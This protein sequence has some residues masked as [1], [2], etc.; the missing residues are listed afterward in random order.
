MPSPRTHRPLLVGMLVAGTVGGAALLVIAATSGM[1][2]FDSPLAV[3]PPSDTPAGMVWV[4][5][6]T[7]RMGGEDPHPGKRA[8]ELPVHDV[9]LDGFWM[10]A[11]E[12]TNAQ[13]AA[14]VAATGYATAAERT[15]RREDFAGQTDIAAI[16]DEMLVPGSICFN[17]NFDRETLRQGFPGWEYQVWRQ[18]EGANWREPEGPGSSIANRMDHPVVHVAWDDAVAYCRWAGKDL[19]TEAEWE[20]A[21]RGG[22]VGATYPWGNELRPDGQWRNNIWQGKFPFENQARDGFAATAPVQ[23]F[24]PND[25]GLFDMSGNVWEW[26]ADWYRPDYYENSKRRNPAG[27]DKSFDPDEPR[28]PKRVQRGGS[29]M[30][31]DDYCIGYRAA[32]RMKG[33]PSSGAFHTGFRCVVRAA[34]LDEYRNAPAHQARAQ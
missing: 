18:V 25:Y 17:P 31:S 9:A 1:A 21:A 7:F 32:A 24:P 10:D 33:D 19:P 2:W 26:C 12:V 11:T 6:G 27:P 30:C 28:I 5:G 16:P 3:G 20:Y 8:D 29:F 23:S 15:P 34:K 13:F 14:F 4:P 22:R